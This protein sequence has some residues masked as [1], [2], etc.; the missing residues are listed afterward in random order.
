MKNV[1]EFKVEVGKNIWTWTEIFY[2]PE[3]NLETCIDKYHDRKEY[4]F[5]KKEDVKWKRK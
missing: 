2:T 1:I 4:Q 3:S 5:W